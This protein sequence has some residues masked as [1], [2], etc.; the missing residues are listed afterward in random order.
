MVAAGQN[1]RPSCFGPS[2]HPSLDFPRSAFLRPP[3]AGHPGDTGDLVGAGSG[4]H[5]S[6]VPG[7]CYVEPRREGRRRRQTAAMMGAFLSWPANRGGVTA[8]LQGRGGPASDSRRGSVQGRNPLPQS[9]HDRGQSSRPLCG[10]YS[11]KKAVSRIPVRSE[12]LSRK[13]IV[14]RVLRRVA[15]IVLASM[16]T[17]GRACP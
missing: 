14:S 1:A 2:G 5:R 10:R 11:Y 4:R 3:T 13:D 16:R 15:Q 8:C 7:Q 17:E 12:Q 9:L 6:L